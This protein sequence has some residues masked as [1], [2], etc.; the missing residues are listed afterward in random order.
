[1]SNPYLFSFD[2]LLANMLVDYSNL[3]EA[4]DTSVGSI[5]W[6]KCAVLAS[7]IWGI[8][9]YQDWV[10]A[11]PFPDTADTD[12][13]NHW[14]N[15]FGV[16]RLALENDNDYAQRIISYLRQPPA[17]GTALD[18]ENWALSTP[19]IAGGYTVASAYVATPPTVPAGQT[20]IVIY[21]SDDSILHTATMDVLV[22]ACQAVIDAN[23]PVTSALNTV[24]AAEV[25]TVPVTATVSPVTSNVAQMITD[26][27]AYMNALDPGQQLYISQLEAL[28]IND[29]A[30]SANVIIP[31][32][33]TS[34]TYAQVI[35]PGIVT[36]TGA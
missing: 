11:Q 26:V 28:M 35:R 10:S 16:S 29:G 4:P 15:I 33:D 36:I 7:A 5:T 8:Y 1:M 30:I 17:G 2:T 24:V 19:A 32:T 22:A 21:P 13:L 27:T 18:Y 9:K 34:I 12:N 20:V 23:A 14:G 25:V 31:I 3:D 6:I